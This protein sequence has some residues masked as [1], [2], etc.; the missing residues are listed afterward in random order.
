MLRDNLGVLSEAAGISL[1]GVREEAPDRPRR[2]R[3]ALGP[4]DRVVIGHEHGEGGDEG[5]GRLV[6]FPADVGRVGAPTSPAPHQS[7]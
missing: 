1:S 5:L 3:P 2:S 6:A 7:T 4:G